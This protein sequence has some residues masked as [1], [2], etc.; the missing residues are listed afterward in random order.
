MNW[1]ATEKHRE[2]NPSEG[3][4]AEE[5]AAKDEVHQPTLEHDALPEPDVDDEVK[6]RASAP[7]ARSGSVKE[8]PRRVG[9]SAVV[10]PA[11]NQAPELRVNG[12]EMLLELLARAS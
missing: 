11:R 7:R 6:A 9:M 4:T 12:D 2:P 8:R 10:L 5:E 1:I 3:T